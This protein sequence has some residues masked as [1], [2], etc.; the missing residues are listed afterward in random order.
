MAICVAVIQHGRS[1]SARN[2]VRFQ[3]GQT[4]AN[5]FEVIARV[6]KRCHQLCPEYNARVQSNHSN[7]EHAICSQICCD[8]LLYLLLVV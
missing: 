1:V 4:S 7:Y 8:E 3:S 2:I 6:P 5:L